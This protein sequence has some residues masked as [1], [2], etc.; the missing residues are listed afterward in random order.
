MAFKETGPS[1]LLNIF[2]GKLFVKKDWANKKKNKKQ[3]RTFKEFLLDVVES[4]RHRFASF[5][6]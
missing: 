5:D 6:M 2:F 3:N 4:I 1:L